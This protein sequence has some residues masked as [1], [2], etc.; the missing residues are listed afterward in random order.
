MAHLQSLRIFLL[1]TVRLPITFEPL[2][3]FE[4]TRHCPYRHCFCIANTDS[5]L[6][7][8]G[9]CSTFTHVLL[10]S[11]WL[12]YEAKVLFPEPLDPA[13]TGI[14]MPKNII[15]ASVFEYSTRAFTD[16]CSEADNEF[17]RVSTS[18]IMPRAYQPRQPG[19]GAAMVEKALVKFLWT[20]EG[21]CP[22]GSPVGST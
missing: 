11:S 3:T 2:D 14:K 20:S 13:S 10:E 21:D 8:L 4:P 15:R 17:L 5:V 6:L 18:S 1:Q 9:R 19:L 22:A 7:Q 12:E 16:A